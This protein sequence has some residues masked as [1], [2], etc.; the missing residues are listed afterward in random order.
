MLKH[1]FAGN[2]NVNYNANFNS[3]VNVSVNV[4]ADAY[5]FYTLTYKK[6]NYHIKSRRISDGSLLTTHYLLL[7]T[8]PSALWPLA[9]NLTLLLHSAGKIYTALDT[10][11]NYRVYYKGNVLCRTAIFLVKPGPYKAGH[12]CGNKL[13]N[14]NLKLT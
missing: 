6:E 7:A 14:V 13:N 8:R 3:D 10:V 11:S 5:S 2:T 9:L 4:N 1:A 12:T